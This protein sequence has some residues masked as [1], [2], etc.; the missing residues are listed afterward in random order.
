MPEWTMDPGMLR[1]QVQLQSQSATPDA[2]G[3]PQQVWTTFLTAMAAIQSTA[4]RESFQTGQFVAEVTHRIT[5]RWPGE[6]VTLQGGQRVLYGARIFLVQTVENV[7]ERDS[8]VHL[9]C[10]EINGTQGTA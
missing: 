3:Q 10:L 9:M 7:R 5:L 8:L 1:R 2:V 6:T 4:A